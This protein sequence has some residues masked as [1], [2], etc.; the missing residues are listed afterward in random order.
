MLRGLTNDR[1]SRIAYLANVVFE[2]DRATA[3]DP[4]RRFA[5]TMELPPAYRRKM[6]QLKAATG[7]RSQATLIRYL[8]DAEYQRRF[9]LKVS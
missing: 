7:S 8:I 9:P 3:G 1:A 5:L 2:A 4:N 6:E